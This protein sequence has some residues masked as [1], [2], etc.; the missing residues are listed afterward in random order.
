MTALPWPS[1]WTRSWWETV[2]A[3]AL[4]YLLF[5]P[6]SLVVGIIVPYIFRMWIAKWLHIEE[7]NLSILISFLQYYS[8][9][10]LAILVPLHFF[11][12]ANTMI[13]S[14]ALGGPLVLL[15]IA[16]FVMSALGR[17]GSYDGFDLWDML[18]FPAGVAFGAGSVAY[19]RRHR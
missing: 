15:F 14:V 8:T 16:G 18:A 4:A 12:R 2:A 1:K 5:V 13:A 3:S 11:K 9:T 10:S 19:Q 7:I 6:V 17:L